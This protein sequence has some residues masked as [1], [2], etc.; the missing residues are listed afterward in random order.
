MEVPSLQTPEAAG[1][2]AEDWAELRIRGLRFAYKHYSYI[3][4]L[5]EQRVSVEDLVHEAIAAIHGE[6]RRRP[7]DVDSFVFLCGV[8]RSKVY[9]L[10]ER[11]RAAMAEQR[12]AHAPPSSGQ[13]EEAGGG[14]SYM[15]LCDEI[16]R[17]VSDD[18]ELLRIVEVW[19]AE[20][21]MK[22]GDVAC[23]LDLS[24]GDVYN[25]QKRLKRKVTSLREKWFR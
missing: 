20:P 12:L 7:A 14:H 13:Q 5:T 24:V 4:Y 10:R 17:L 23:Q 21:D 3:P 6:K 15:Q 19:F 25:A 11:K 2:P 16:Q 18:P 8:I 1:T 22:P 9:H